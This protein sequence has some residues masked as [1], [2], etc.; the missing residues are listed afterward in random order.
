MEILTRDKVLAA[1]LCLVL[2]CDIALH[3]AGVRRHLVKDLVRGGGE[4]EEEKEVSRWQAVRHSGLVS[5]F[6]LAFKSSQAGAWFSPVHLLNHPAQVAGSDL[7][8]ST[9]HCLKDGVVYEDVL[10]LLVH[11]VATHDIAGIQ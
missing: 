10:L 6:K 11:G 5:H 4:G 1:V 8:V 9:C 3:L 2:E 7:C